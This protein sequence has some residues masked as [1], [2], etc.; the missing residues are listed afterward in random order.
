MSVD[1]SW[2]DYTNMNFTFLQFVSAKIPFVSARMRRKEGF[3]GRNSGVFGEPTSRA[4][5]SPPKEDFMW[6]ATQA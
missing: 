6:K 1:A 2:H 3:E 4:A 5:S